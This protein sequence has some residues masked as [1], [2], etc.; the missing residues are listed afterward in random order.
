MESLPNELH[1]LI[2][3]YLHNF[4]ILYG[5][6]NLNQRFQRIIQ[7]Y[8]CDIDLTQ[9]NLS[10]KQFV[11]LMEQIIPVQGS[12][13]RSLKFSVQHHLPLLR[14]RQL[15]NL[16][17]LTIVGYLPHDDNYTFLTD[18]LSLST[19]SELSIHITGQ[20]MFRIIS[21]NAS[22][23]LTKLILQDSLHISDSYFNDIQ[24]MPYIKCLSIRIDSNKI[25]LNIFQPMPNLVQLNLLL[26]DYYNAE[27]VNLKELPVT[28]KKLQIEID[29]GK[30]YQANFELI[31]NLFNLF[32]N[33]INE[34]TVIIREA[35]EE[36][37]NF[38]KLQSLTNNFIHLQIFNYNILTTYQP[39]HRFSSIIQFPHSETYSFFTLPKSKP[40]FIE[41]NQDTSSLHVNNYSTLEK[42]FNSHSV[43]ISTHKISQNF[44]SAFQ[45]IKDDY[46]FNNLKQL[47][48]DCMRKGQED[49][50]QYSI[51]TKI[52]DQS[53][54]LDTIF[55]RSYR[56]E[57]IIIYSKNLFPKKNSNKIKNLLIREHT[58]NDLRGSSSDYAGDTPASHPP[59]F[60]STF[61]FQLSQILPDLQQLTFVCD[62]KFWAIYS[63][64]NCN[65]LNDLRQN[66]PKLTHLK[67]KMTFL[68]NKVFQSFK[69]RLNKTIQ[70]N[71]SL[72]YTEYVDTSNRLRPVYDL[73]IWL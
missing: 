49:S 61:F 13:V 47:E 63:T 8:L 14:L 15:I 32:N 33:Q 62:K 17:S 9:T 60:H 45:S 65:C 23:R 54:N 4:D 7:S 50:H 26:S 39:D 1:F 51:L 71:N 58:N 46:N 53:P 52:I 6:Y 30:L 16:Q 24:Q 42:L 67:L 22:Q 19:L 59:K 34:L 69:K 72:F 40:I 55:I 11:L 38:E 56:T 12:L 3:R 2:F 57:I 20:N 25:L 28:L 66:F 10:Y 44:P 27:D 5:F 29:Y 70:K 36:L 48:L 18:A 43:C 64:K 21:T 68:G 35:P 41:L 31:N 73:N 37:S